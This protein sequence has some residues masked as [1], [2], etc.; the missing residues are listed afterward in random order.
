[1][2]RG[3]KQPHSLTVIHYAA[4]FIYL[5]VYLASFPWATLTDKIGLTKL[6][7]ILLDSMPSR[8][9]KQAYVQGFRFYSITF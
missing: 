1:M 5:N 8:W 2:R 4:R 6:N 9:Y 3:M 7:E